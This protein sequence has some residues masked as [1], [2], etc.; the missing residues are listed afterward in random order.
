[1]KTLYMMIV[2]VVLMSSVCLADN[3][4]G[5]YSEVTT[6]VLATSV[7]GP[8]TR[9]GA[10]QNTN[11]FWGIFGIGNTG[12]RNAVKDGNITEISYVDRVVRSYFFG[13]V[14]NEEVVVYGK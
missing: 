10:S 2:M 6:P 14:V 12:I 13:I 1:M 7:S 11:V 9:I 5:F 3:Y 8:I 4:F